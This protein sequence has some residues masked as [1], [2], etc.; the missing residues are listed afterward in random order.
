MKRITRKIAKAG[1]IKLEG[2]MK[3]EIEERAAAVRRA[4]AIC[5]YTTQGSK[6]K[7]CLSI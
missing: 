4:K 7:R 5:V 2:L 3:D 6:Y 1:K